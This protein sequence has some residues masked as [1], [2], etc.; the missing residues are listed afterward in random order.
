MP[1]PYA[2]DTFMLNLDGIEAALQNKNHI[3]FETEFSVFNFGLSIYNNMFVTFG[4]NYKL[5][6]NFQYPKALMELRRGNYREDN[7]PLSFD[8]GQNFNFYREIFAGF[9]MEVTPEITVG[10]RL[11]Y[12]QGIANISTSSMK[13]DWYTETHQDSMYDWTF[14]SDFEI[15]ASVP[16]EW[17][18]EHNDDDQIEEIIIDSTYFDEFSSF[19]KDFLFP[20]NTGFAVDLG[21]EY[22]LLD[23]FLFSASVVDLG[24]IN[25]KQNPVTL[26]QEATFVFDGLD[27]SKY[28]GS[29]DD[30]TAVDSTIGERI[31]SDIVDTLMNV[32]NP[33]IERTKYRKGINP[34]IYLGANAK[35]TEWLDFGFL[36]RG[37]FF[38]KEL[39]SSYT[40][41][42]NTNFFKGWSY[43]VSY[44]LMDGL[45]NNLG[46][47]LAY[48]VG[49]F[50][51]YFITDNFS[52]PFWAVNGSEFADKWIRNTKRASF[53]FG[54]NILICGN[55]Y[56]IGLL[57]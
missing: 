7:T 17:D 19:Y 36:Y 40:L 32:F 35:V 27:I 23:R 18:I 20:K 34:K 37:M 25:W 39:Y 51:M 1:H 33:D 38:N 21:V 16:I 31:I 5:F 42:A 55:K 44:S 11:K 45:A 26:T 24:F 50:Q 56:D 54:M 49:P 8:L 13:I 53:A 22:N 3:N 41:S 15:N 52:V 14:E 12:L 6:E 47:G 29:L 28:I 2:Q 57:E 43:S 48:K 30:A 9:S 46:M 4:I 10:G